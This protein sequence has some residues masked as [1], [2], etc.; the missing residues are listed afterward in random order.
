[1]EAAEGGTAFIAGHE[2]KAGQDKVVHFDNQP[3]VPCPR[4]SGMVD[5]NRVLKG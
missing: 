5:I 2:P 1:M 3:L 4:A